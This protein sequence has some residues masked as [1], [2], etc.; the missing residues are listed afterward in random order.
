MS[1]HLQLVQY[2]NIEWDVQVV[3]ISL[4]WEFRYIQYAK[5]PVS[6]RF[7]ISYAVSDIHLVSC[8]SLV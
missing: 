4:L 3:S 7:R 2:V 6:R 8:L 5:S 1:L